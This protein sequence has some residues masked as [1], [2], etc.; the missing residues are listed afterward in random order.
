MACVKGETLD[1]ETAGTSVV[2]LKGDYKKKKKTSSPEWH[3]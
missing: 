3:V 2:K 1:F